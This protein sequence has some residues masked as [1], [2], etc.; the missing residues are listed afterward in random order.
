M[1]NPE[2][3]TEKRKWKHMLVLTVLR[4]LPAVM[5]EYKA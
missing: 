4:W 1:N 2:T 5:Q 3:P